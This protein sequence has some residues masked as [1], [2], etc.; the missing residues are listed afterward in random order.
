LPSSVNK[1]TIANTTGVTLTSAV[2]VNDTLSL[3]GS[4]SLAANNLTIAPAGAITGVTGAVYVVT[5]GSGKLRRTVSNNATD[6]LFPV[7]N[8][9]YSPARVQLTGGSTADVFEVRSMTG[10]MTAGATGLP[11]TTQVVNRTWDITESV[12][13]GSTATVNLAWD[14]SVETAGF[15]RALC[16]VSYYTGAGW[17]FAT[18]TASYGP[19]VFAAGQWTRVRSGITTLGFFAVGDGASA[20]PVKLVQFAATKSGNDAVLN[21]ATAQG[22]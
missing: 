20:L 12:V 6:V 5:N 1:L 18:P 2:T 7:G 9:Q 14:D 8:A 17:R 19:A 3:S 22:G 4:L 21:W 15:N 16:A 13:G 11:I 10:V